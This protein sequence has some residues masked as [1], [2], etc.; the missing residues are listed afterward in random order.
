MPT[1]PHPINFYKSVMILNSFENGM[2]TIVVFM[3]I[4]KAFDRVWHHG[5][6]VKLENN[7]IKVRLLRW[8]KN[9]LYGRFQGVVL[10]GV[11]SNSL[12]NAG[13]PQGSILAPIQ[14]LLYINDITHDQLCN[15]MHSNLFVQSQASNRTM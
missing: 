11:Q 3:D 7:G 15:I 13:V 6:L 1:T 2:E 10:D 12:P 4:S 14:F 8:F 9:Y 5:M